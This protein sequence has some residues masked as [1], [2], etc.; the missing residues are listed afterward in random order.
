MNN[1]HDNGD[2]NYSQVTTKNLY[3]E[4]IGWNTVDHLCMNVFVYM[5]ITEYLPVN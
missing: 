5:P 2:D 1:D 4:R 3:I